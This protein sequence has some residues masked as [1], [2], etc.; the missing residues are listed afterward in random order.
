L[1]QLKD[2][3]EKARID[4]DNQIQLLIDAG[5]D[6]EKGVNHQLEFEDDPEFDNE[7]DEFEPDDE[8]FEPDDEDFEPDDED[9]EPENDDFIPEDEDQDW[10]EHAYDELQGKNEKKKK[11]DSRLDFL[12]EEEIASGMGMRSRV[13]GPIPGE[14]SADGTQSGAFGAAPVQTKSKS[15]SDPEAPD[16][17]NMPPS[18][19]NPA[20]K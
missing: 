3:F 9:F 10:A 6:F 14:S 1:T 17:E 20:L 13:S 12:T 11:K 7:D 19:F 18:K 4:A 5:V 16:Y 15:I 2:E 8:D